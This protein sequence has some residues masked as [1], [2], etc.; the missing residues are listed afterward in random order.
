MYE[1]QCPVEVRVVK[2]KMYIF[3][4]WRCRAWSYTDS[5]GKDTD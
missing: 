5:F 3:G 2:E 4:S 1:F